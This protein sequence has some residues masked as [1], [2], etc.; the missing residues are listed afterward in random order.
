MMRTPFCLLPLSLA[1]RFGGLA[2]LAG[3]NDFL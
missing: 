3:A 2:A 1:L